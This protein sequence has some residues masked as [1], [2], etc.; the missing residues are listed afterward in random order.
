MEISMFNLSADGVLVRLLSALIIL[1]IGYIAGRLAKKL[2]VKIFSWLGLRKILREKLNTDIEFDRIIPNIIKYVIY[3]VALGLGI[4]SLGWLQMVG[5]IVGVVILIVVLVVLFVVLKN[6]F[7]N[8]FLGFS[9]HYDKRIKIGV[10]IKV[11]SIKGR[12]AKINPTGV[13]VKTNG[14]IVV[15]PNE[16][17]KKSL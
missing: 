17:L 4:A 13:K 10:E 7:I 16:F 8:L 1:V 11:G 5:Q 3:A 2:L 14:R 9:L 6:F 15:I 12:I